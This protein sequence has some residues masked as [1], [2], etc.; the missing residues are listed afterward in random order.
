MSKSF[1][2]TGTDTDCGKT[3]MASGLLAAAKQQGLS[4]AGIKPVAAGCLET[5]DGLRNDDALVLQQYYVTVE[6]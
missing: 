1:F 2:V 3:L 6:L 5:P 4:T